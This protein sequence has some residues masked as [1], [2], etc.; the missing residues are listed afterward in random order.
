MREHREF[1]RSEGKKS[2]RLVVIAAEGR[3]TE[4][5]YFQELAK[6]LC[7]SKVHVVFL[8]REN[9]KLESRICI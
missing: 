1:K 2:S 6:K 3:D 4:R 5:I 7:S 8:C 9:N